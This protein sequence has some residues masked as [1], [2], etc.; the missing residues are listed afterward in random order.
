M[1]TIYSYGSWRK[2]GIIEY[3]VDS[4]SNDGK[5]AYRNYL[6]G[7]RMIPKFH[8]YCNF[9]LNRDEALEKAK[10]EITKEI[11]AHNRAVARLLQIG[12]NLK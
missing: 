8:K 1:I 12:I 11:E 9:C 7:D 3:Q 4:I 5:V 10:L 2:H 6:L